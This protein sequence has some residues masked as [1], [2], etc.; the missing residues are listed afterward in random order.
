MDICMALTNQQDFF[1]F[2]K[3]GSGKKKTN[4]QTK[5]HLPANAENIR[6]TGLIPGLRRSPGGGHGHPLQD[7]CLEN[8]RGQRKVAS[9]SPWG[10]EESDMQ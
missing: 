5:K 1:F 4:K 6:G 2:F 3:G 9:Y 10:R 8:P 7:S